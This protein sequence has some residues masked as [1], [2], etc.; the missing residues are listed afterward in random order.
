MATPDLVVMYILKSFEYSMVDSPSLMH[1]DP[2]CW[3]VCF[4]SSGSSAG[5]RK[6]PTFSSRTG[7]PNWMQFSSVRR[8][9]L[10][11]CLSTVR[12][13]ERSVVLIQRLAMS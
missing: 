3:K 5:S 9:S 1:T 2:P 13:L 6:S 11:D 8:K 12:P 10:S 7:D 4:C